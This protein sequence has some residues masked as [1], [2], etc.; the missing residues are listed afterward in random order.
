MLLCLLLL[1]LPTASI[2]V[3]PDIF[4]A[5]KPECEEDMR[6]KR[7][8]EVDLHYTGWIDDSSAAGMPGMEL[9]TTAEDEGPFHMRVGTGKMLRGVEIGLIGLCPGTR[10]TMIIPP[11]L[12][13]GIKKGQ[14]E[15]GVPANC[16]LKVSSLPSYL[17]RSSLGQTKHSSMSIFSPQ[18]H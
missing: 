5:H 1:V 18:R 11:N 9:D 4:F 7:G 15:V 2:K 10:A 6:I 8:H 3:K 14:P 12:A 17:L 13:F 16:T